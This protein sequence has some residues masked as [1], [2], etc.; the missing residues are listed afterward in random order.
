MH[1]YYDRQV[2]KDTALRTEE[3]RLAGV[4]VGSL[5]GQTLKI[6]TKVWNPF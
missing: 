3:F 4:K 5:S 6:R 1:P 2:A